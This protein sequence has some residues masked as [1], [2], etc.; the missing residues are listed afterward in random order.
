MSFE[1]D[2]LD[3]V[4][5]HNDR[6][7]LLPLVYSLLS[8]TILTELHTRES[9]TLFHSRAPNI[10]V[11]EYLQRIVKYLK[12]EVSILSH[13][14]SSKPLTVGPEIVSF[15]HIVLHRS[16]LCSSAPFY[17]VLAYLPP[18]RHHLHRAF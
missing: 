12:V 8:E 10:T 6:I 9:L 13:Y 3:R 4:M 14:Y 2:M 16:N 7:P 18:R 11:L 17:T 5:A 15:T 1:A